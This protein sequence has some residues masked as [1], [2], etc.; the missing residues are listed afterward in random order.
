MVA[1]R[2]RARANMDSLVNCIPLASILGAPALDGNPGFDQKYEV[3]G[4]E[5]RVHPNLLP[6]S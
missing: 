5:S 3:R 1:V 2:G 4:E 6:T